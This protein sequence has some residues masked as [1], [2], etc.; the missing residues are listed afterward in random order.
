MIRRQ[1]KRMKRRRRK[2]GLKGLRHGDRFGSLEFLACGRVGELTVFLARR[3]AGGKELIGLG[4]CRSGLSESEFH[5]K[6][7]LTCSGGLIGT[8]HFAA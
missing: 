3:R 4:T 2:R 1:A 8:P 6:L 5:S 7:D